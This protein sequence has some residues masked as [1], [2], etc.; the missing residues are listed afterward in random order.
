MFI[1]GGDVGQL[2]EQMPQILFELEPHLQP[3]RFEGDPRR[4]FSQLARHTVDGASN[5]AEAGLRGWF[6][7]RYQGRDLLGLLP[8]LAE[9][10]AV[11]QLFQVRLDLRRGD[12]ERVFLLGCPQLI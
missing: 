10:W 12:P 7:D 11:A 2:V 4:Q 9:G 3:A 1:L 6:L 5:A 8:I